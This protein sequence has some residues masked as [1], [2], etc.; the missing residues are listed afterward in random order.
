MRLRLIIGGMATI[1]L[2]A[3]GQQSAA[4]NAANTGAES[5]NAAEPEASANAVDAAANTAAPAAATPGA[6]AAPTKEFIV[7]KWG[8]SGD[9]TLA[10]EFKAD[11]S[12]VGPFERWELNGAELTMVG[13]PDKMVLSVVDDKTMTSRLN[14]TGEP[15]KLTRC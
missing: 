11:G 6:G 13:D 8:D 7:G 4:D 1:V 5:A 10:I 15:H 9:C 14:G 2:A 3:C 12:M